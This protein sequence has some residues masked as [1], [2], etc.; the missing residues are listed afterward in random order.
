MQTD[1]TILVRFKNLSDVFIQMRVTQLDF[2]FRN[3]CC[4]VC[5]AS[6]D[7]L[8]EFR[9]CFQWLWYHHCIPWRGWGA[10]PLAELGHLRSL[11]CSLM[12]LCSCPRPYVYRAVAIKKGG[13]RVRNVSAQILLSLFTGCL[14]LGYRSSHKNV[15]SGFRSPID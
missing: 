9:I 1:K 4:R 12:P 7:D 6:G 5:V 10:E 11:S 13:F 14:V 2:S 3:S 8:R 15:L